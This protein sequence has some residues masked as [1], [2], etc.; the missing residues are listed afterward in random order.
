[1]RQSFQNARK[2][3]LLQEPAERLRK[4]ISQGAAGLPVLSQHY[5]GKIDRI[6]ESGD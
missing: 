6:I 1:M 4:V 2:E 3:S 5:K